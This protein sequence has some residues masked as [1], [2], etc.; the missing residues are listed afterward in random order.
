MIII[1]LIL[2]AFLLVAVLMYILGAY[3]YRDDAK[4]YPKISF[5]QF[6]R[7]RKTAPSKWDFG[8]NRVYYET[9]KQVEVIYFTT[10]FDCLR[11]QWSQNQKEKNQIKEEADKNKLA[12]LKEWQND[13]DE[14][15]KEYIDLLKELNER[16]K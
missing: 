12:L 5:D 8:Y 13:I 15:R 9:D 1:L 6:Q 4:R 14:Y 11:Y 3:S 7:L 2:F 10:Y 16:E